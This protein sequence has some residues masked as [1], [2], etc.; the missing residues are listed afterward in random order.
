M[1]KWRKNEAEGE[2]KKKV[3]KNKYKVML[4]REREKRISGKYNKWNITKKIRWI[5]GNIKS[6]YYEEK[7]KRKKKKE[8]K[9]RKKKKK[10]GEG[11]RKRKKHKIV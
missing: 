9:R 5:N 10:K 1:E 11:R 3:G 7:K 6:G 2:R 4:W 8:E